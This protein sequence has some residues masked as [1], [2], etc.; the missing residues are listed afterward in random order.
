MVRGTVFPSCLWWLH[1]CE[2]SK[3]RRAARSG[4][5]E[6]V[7][8]LLLLSVFVFTLVWTYITQ[9]LLN[10]MHNFNEYMFRSQGWWL[11][12][13]LV[14]VTLTA[15]LLTYCGV[16]LLLS[17]CLVLC[18]H[19]LKLHWLHKVLVS[20]CALT[21]CLGV[22]GLDLKW[23]E[24]WAAVFLSLQATAPFLHIGAVIGTSALAWV[25]AGY[26]WRVKSRGN[27]GRDGGILTG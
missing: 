16:L 3:R 25:L 11:D 22:V 26:Y 8:V 24:E 13:S 19:P 15:V 27:W 14:L 5:C 10:D 6:C 9:I 23:R 7:W 21:V 18:A 4:T 17:L 2:G 1:S 12:W 20:L